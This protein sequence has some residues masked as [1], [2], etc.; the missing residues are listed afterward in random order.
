M[1][2]VETLTVIDITVFIIIEERNEGE[3]KLYI[4]TVTT[5]KVTI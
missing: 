2:V 4:W 3:N 1:R 5:A